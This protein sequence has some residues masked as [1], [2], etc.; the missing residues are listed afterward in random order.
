MSKSKRTSIHTS[1]ELR[2]FLCECINNVANGTIDTEKARN[3]TKLAAQVNESVYAE[4]KAAK[5]Q[6]ELGRVAPSIGNMN[7]HG[8]GDIA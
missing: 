1:G 8:G 2:E 6:I 4:L 3:I 5:T 7:L